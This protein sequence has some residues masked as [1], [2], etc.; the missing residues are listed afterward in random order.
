MHTH[1]PVESLYRDISLAFIFNQGKAQIYMWSEKPM[2]IKCE[3]LLAFNCSCLRAPPQA[4]FDGLIFFLSESIL[5]GLARFF[6]LSAE[7]S[8]LVREQ[9]YC[10]RVK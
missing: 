4:S 9:T 5:S 2:L 3:H 10:F 1:I 6:F 8:R 7:A